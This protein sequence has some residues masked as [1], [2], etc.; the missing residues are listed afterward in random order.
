ME[1]YL[2]LI[3]A[4]Y[5]VTELFPKEGE[6]LKLQIRTSADKALA[7]LLLNRQTKI[8]DLLM[9]FDAAEAKNWID[10]RNFAVLRCEYEKIK[11]NQSLLGPKVTKTRHRKILDIINER[12]KV[13]VRELAQV[14]PDLSRRTLI[15]DL[16]ELFHNG[17][18]VRTGSG[19]GVCYANKIVT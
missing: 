5:K 18:V 6:E 7:D 9:L 12:N 15:R 13:Q 17:I 8:D 14:F 19:R 10:P 2:K 16:E 1:F 4:V 11:T 3:L